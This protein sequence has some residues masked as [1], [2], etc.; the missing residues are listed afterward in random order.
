[1]EHRHKSLMLK[2]KKDQA[3]NPPAAKPLRSRWIPEDDPTPRV[4]VSLIQFSDTSI[5][6]S[7][8]MQLV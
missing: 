6:T 1:M 4:N 8:Q 7:Q 3:E 2:S 5:D